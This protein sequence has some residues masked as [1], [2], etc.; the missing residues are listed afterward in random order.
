[1]KYTSDIAC[2]LGG[3]SEKVEAEIRTLRTV[4]ERSNPSL[5]VTIDAPR[6]VVA[7]ASNDSVTVDGSLE[8][9]VVWYVWVRTAQNWNGE[10]VRFNGRNEFSF[11]IC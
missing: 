5:V 4:V 2:A 9:G 7:A 1:M 10:K 11:S 3:T 6:D 8:P